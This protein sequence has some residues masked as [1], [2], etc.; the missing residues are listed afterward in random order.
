MVDC[1]VSINTIE[2]FSRVFVLSLYLR[3]ALID[4]SSISDSLSLFYRDLPL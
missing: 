1:N 4:A 3:L 2:R